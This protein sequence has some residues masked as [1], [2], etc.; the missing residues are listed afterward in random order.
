M[1]RA[2]VQTQEQKYDWMRAKQLSKTAKPLV[3]V[4]KPEPTQSITESQHDVL[5]ET[6]TSVDMFH[7]KKWKYQEAADHL[8]ISKGTLRRLTMVELA[9]GAT[10]IGHLRIG[11]KKAHTLYTYADSALRRIY[12]RMTG[13]YYNS[14]EMKFTS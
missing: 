6:Q 3:V 9:E 1:S 8:A 14:R 7:E 13:G 5:F 10:G 12:N 4:G 11:P 2:R